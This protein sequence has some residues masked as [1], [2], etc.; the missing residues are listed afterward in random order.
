MLAAGAELCDQCGNP[1][2]EEIAGSRML[3]ELHDYEV[4][5]PLSASERELVL[6]R[7]DASGAVDLD[8]SRF[9]EA[10]TVHHRHAALRQ[11]DGNWQL[12]QL[13]RNPLV[14]RGQGQSRRLERGESAELADEDEVIV[15]RVRLRFRAGTA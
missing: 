10:G 3:A 7:G 9:A 14:V 2:L 11:A 4:V 1:R 8:L 5:L 15:G 6:G 13:G 12:T